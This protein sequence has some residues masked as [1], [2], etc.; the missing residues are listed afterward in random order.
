MQPW[1]WCHLPISSEDGCPLKTAMIALSAWIGVPA[2]AALGAMIQ[3]GL[4]SLLSHCHGACYGS[5]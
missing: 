1:P 2:S 3:L 5:H 4:L